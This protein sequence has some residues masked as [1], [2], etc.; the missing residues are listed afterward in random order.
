MKILLLG[1]TGRTGKVILQKA[2]NDGYEVRAIVRDK[3][4]LDGANADII[5]GTPYDRDAVMSAVKGCDAVISTLN[6]SRT[7]DSP[8]AKL[9]SP[10]DLISRSVQNAVEGMKENDVKRII[11]LSTLGAGDSKDRMPKLFNLFI[12][13]SNLKYAFRDHTRQEEILEQSD[14]DWTV[15]RLPMLTAD[16]GEN[17]VLVN[18]GDG[19]RLNR[20]VNRETVARF[21]L[22]ILNE[23]K[24]FKKKIAIS[25]KQT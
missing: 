16:A 2:I 5:E 1:A 7:S 17:E 22:N 19:T 9:R 11:V 21:I 10:K 15:I 20:K 25:N 14:R 6:V 24:Y 18:M 4:K 3:S 23:E 13:L 8:W 12:S